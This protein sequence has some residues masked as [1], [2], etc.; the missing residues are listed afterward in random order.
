[1]RAGLW[2]VIVG[3]DF[4]MEKE[5]LITVFGNCLDLFDNLFLSLPLQT[6]MVNISENILSNSVSEVE[7]VVRNTRRGAKL[8]RRKVIPKPLLTTPA[9]VP[10]TSN[11][12]NK[13]IR[14]E[15]FD[16]IIEN[17]DQLDAI[18]IPKTRKVSNIISTGVL[19]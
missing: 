3:L 15:E 10:L 6:E 2:L 13:T 5:V 1:M 9:S 12:K 11:R 18:V 7:I 17:N 8:T 16:D 19:C 4:K 14:Y